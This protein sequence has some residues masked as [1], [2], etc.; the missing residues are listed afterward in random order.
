MGGAEPWLGSGTGNEWNLSEKNPGARARDPVNLKQARRNS[1]PWNDKKDVVT[2]HHRSACVGQWKLVA[3]PLPDIKSQAAY[4][5]SLLFR[6]V[7]TDCAS[8]AQT[9]RHSQES[10]VA[11][12]D[13]HEIVSRAK[14][15]LTHNALVDQFC[16]DA[17]VPATECE[18][19]QL[20]HVGGCL[21]AVFNVIVR[22]SDHPIFG[23]LNSVAMLSECRGLSPLV[24]QNRVCRRA[25][26]GQRYRSFVQLRYLDLLPPAY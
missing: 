20:A 15:N 23:I 7:Q 19:M 25:Q 3:E 22:V 26:L 11:T 17:L 13:V 1:L 16:D 8:H 12:S 6:C 14:T 21:A 2:D 4:E 18:V 10:T 5:G 9:L 24:L